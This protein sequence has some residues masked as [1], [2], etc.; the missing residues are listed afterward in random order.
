M[1]I[2]ARKVCPDCMLC[3]YQVTTTGRLI[4]QGQL[5]VSSG[6]SITDGGLTI[7][8]TSLITGTSVVDAGALS[9]TSS[10]TGV[11]ALNIYA[12]RAGYTGNVLSGRTASGEVSGNLMTLLTGTAVEFQA[13]SWLCCCTGTCRL[14]QHVLFAF[15][16]YVRYSYR[17]LHADCCYRHQLQ[18][19]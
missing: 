13:C 3:W 15:F 1:V 9:I 16:L 6:V 5:R 11:T 4:S 14:L 17:L 12:S 18:T 8:G 2:T 7:V 10:A 19:M